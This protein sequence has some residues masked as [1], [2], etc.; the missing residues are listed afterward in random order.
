MWL[1]AL[2]VLVF[3]PWLVFVAARWQD[4]ENW[5]LVI[6][7]VMTPVYLTVAAVLTYVYVGLRRGMSKETSEKRSEPED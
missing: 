3:V 7:I 6:S 5:S 1:F 2:A 4:A